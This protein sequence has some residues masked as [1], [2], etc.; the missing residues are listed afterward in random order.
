MRPALAL[1]A[2]AAVLFAAPSLRAGPAPGDDDG[3]RVLAP[4][5]ALLHDLDDAG[6]GPRAPLWIGIS[7]TLARREASQS[8]G[9]M[10]LLNIPLERVA[11]AGSGARA[12]GERSL[13][14]GRPAA[15][16]SAAFAEQPKTESRAKT[17]PE[18]EAGDD[19]AA[20]PDAKLAAAAAPADEPLVIPVVVAPELA[21]AAGPPARKKAGL[22]A[23]D[24][25]LEGL[26]GRARAGALL[27]ELRLRVTR[28]VDDSESL[29]P[30]EYDPGRTTASGG[31]SLWLEA[32]A[33]W[34]L[35]RLVFAD[36]EIAI[37]RL[38]ADRAEAEARLTA[39][40]LDLLFAWQRARALEARLDL[41]PDERLAASL[42][43]LEC[44]AALDVATDGWFTRWRAGPRAR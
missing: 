32:R 5:V 7:A 43:V 27:P 15:G 12:D 11:R 40:V 29:S 36:E 38:R 22:V 1:L 21:R 41:A 26:A 17:S 35:D 13:G 6:G 33:T 34:R 39:R 25:R 3:D 44:E 28:L 30:T 8:W 24:A 23:A 9:A 19:D 20:D 31:T 18:G 4:R 14:A 16:G 2:A 10:L 42:K 37:E